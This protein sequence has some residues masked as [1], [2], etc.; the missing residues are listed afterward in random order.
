[1]AYAK[2]TIS[3]A[4]VLLELSETEAAV[5]M[6][7]VGMASADNEVPIEVI[8]AMA[9]ISYALS[10]SGLDKYMT[11]YGARVLTPAVVAPWSLV[12]DDE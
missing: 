7:L 4:K 11:D 6:G 9:S 2:H 10:H 8:A 1:M 12:T 5:V 3:R